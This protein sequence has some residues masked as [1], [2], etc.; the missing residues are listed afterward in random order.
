MWFGFSVLWIVVEV[1]VVGD[2]A[3]GCETVVFLGV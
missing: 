1:E 2:E 3:G